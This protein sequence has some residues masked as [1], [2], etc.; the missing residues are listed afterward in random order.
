MSASK[1]LIILSAGGTAREAAQWLSSA[2]KVVGY[3]DDSKKDASVLGS[4]SAAHEF[5]STALLFSALGSYRSMAWRF[6]FLE[7][8]HS[9]RFVGL[10]AGATI[11][12]SAV[13]DD[14]AVLFPGSVVSADAS[15]GRHTL[16]Y[17]GVI[18]SHDSR[19]D[20]YSIVANGAVVSGGVSIGPNCYVGAN[21][22]ILE[23]RRVGEGSIIAAGAT[24]VCDVPPHSIYF[25]P[26]NIKQNHYLS[27]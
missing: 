14:S 26:R 18:V 19:V 23:G 22:T 27:A 7:R 17:H 1:N 24:V 12:A 2:Y 8:L 11:Y 20:D 5:A 16:I 13:L 10:R 3:L 9:A 21:A 4:L 15:L 25:G 6:G